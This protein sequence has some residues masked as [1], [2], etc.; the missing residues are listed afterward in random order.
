MPPP[1]VIK[2]LVAPHDNLHD[3][4]AAVPAVF[5]ARILPL[6]VEFVNREAVQRSAD[7]IG[8]P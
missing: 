8:K 3:A 2:T 4:I 7:F 6:A 1:A 5:R